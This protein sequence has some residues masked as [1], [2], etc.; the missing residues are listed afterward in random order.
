MTYLF[1]GLKIYLTILDKDLNFLE[2]SP[3]SVLH[4]K[5][6]KHCAK[7]GKIW[8]FVKVEDEMGFPKL[9]IN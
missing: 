3:V 6:V 7:D 1:K 5:P 9:S 4:H 8:M 2:D